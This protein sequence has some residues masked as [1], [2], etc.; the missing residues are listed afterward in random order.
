MRTAALRRQLS[1]QARRRGANGDTVG[2]SLTGSEER[3]RGTVALHVW[4]RF[5]AFLG[6][7]W[8]SAV[9]VCAILAQL[10]QFAQS[11]WLSKWASGAYGTGPSTLWLYSAPYAGLTLLICVLVLVRSLALYYSFLG[12]S[13]HMHSKTLGGVLAS[14]MAFF[15]STPLGRILSRFSKELQNIDVALNGPAQRVIASLLRC[16][17]AVYFIVYGSS[18]YLLLLFPPLM[19]GWYILQYYYRASARELQRLNSISKSP[20]YSA[21]NEALN[22]CSTIQAFGATERLCAEQA[23]RFD[24]N[25]RAAFLS[26]AVGIWLEVW[27]QCMSALV[28]GGAALFCVIEGKA[29]EGEA[30]GG[31]TRAALAGLALTYAPQ[32]T[33]SLNQLL[34]AFMNLETNMVSVERCFQYT[35]LQPEEPMDKADREEP[36]AQWPSRGAIEFKQAVMR[37]RPELDDALTGASFTIAGGEKVGV[38]GRTGSGKSTLLTCLFRLV[39]LRSGSISI[40]GVNIATV[41]LV[42]LRNRV[43]IIPQDPIFFT[44]TLRYNLDPRGEATDAQLQEI[45]SRCAS[46]SLE[47]SMQLDGGGSNLSAGQRQLLCIVRALLRESRVLVLDEATANLDLQTDALIQRTAMQALGDATT[48]TIAHR[49]NTI[50]GCDKVLVMDGGRVAD[51]SPAPPEELKR[52][53]GSIFAN[54]CKA[55][56]QE[57][58]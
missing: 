9:V 43:A 36:E 4:K 49:L 8:V 2:R 24:H 48:L 14:P 56:Q 25:L 33:D 1:E 40:D 17:C 35:D 3:E 23:A 18:P 41:P 27:L 38:V 39:E 52:K 6:V 15:D 47:L 42:A 10:C 58:Q 29:S 20:L 37:Y 11:L 50:M 45:M 21:F 51:D 32:L 57:E 44:G 16:V 30:S 46:G 34:Q 22:G 26:N 55:A 53:E 13:E 31:A 54:L 12:A 28:I 19:V 5:A 7:G